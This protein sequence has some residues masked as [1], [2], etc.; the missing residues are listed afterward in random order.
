[1][2]EKRGR[3]TKFT[4]AMKAKVKKYFQTWEP[5]YECPVEKQDKDGNVTTI[6]KRVPNGAP[7]A[8]RIADFLGLNRDTIFDWMDSNSPRFSKIFSDCIKKGVEHCFRTGML[9]NGLTGGWSTAMTIFL[10]KNLLGMKDKTETDNTHHFPGK[11]KIEFVEPEEK[12]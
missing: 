8:I 6:M 7:T 5:F 3:P 10:S 1:M 2:T 4:P 11:I 12:E 9:E